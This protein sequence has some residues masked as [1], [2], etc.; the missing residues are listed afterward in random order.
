MIAGWVLIL[1]M[2]SNGY[3]SSVIYTISSIE[4][5]SSEEACIQ[6]GKNWRKSLSTEDI[7]D[8]YLDKIAHFSCSKK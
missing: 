1:T 8:E 7:S 6:E 4:N 5:F 2:F 3:S